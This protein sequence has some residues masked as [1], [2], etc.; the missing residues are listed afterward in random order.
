MQQPRF[1]FVDLVDIEPLTIVDIGASALE[2]AAAYHV[3]AE[4]TASRII[5]FEPDPKACAALNAA[6]RLR[7]SYFPFAIGAGGPATL[8]ETA[9]PPSSSLYK[10][11][12]ELL[13]HFTNFDKLFAVTRTHK[14]ET[15]RLDDVISADEIDF[16]KI[17]VQGA[18][19]DVLRGAEKLL[20]TTLVV[21]T[22]VEFLPMYENQPLFGDIDAH[23]RAAGFQL[24]TFFDPR[25]PFYTPLADPQGGLGD[26][27]QVMWTDAI[28]VPDVRRLHL[29][30][31]ERLFKLVT[32]L[33]E[34]YGSVDL[35]AHILKHMR[36]RGIETPFNEYMKRCI[37]LSRA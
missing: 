27:S 18:E 22:E 20:P 35:C 12:A 21:Q 6:G 15:H 36:K 26:F 5:G 9:F 29:Y 14:V 37:A 34:M 13:S 32:L 3:L 4:R 16:L 28:Y 2:G 7:H 19:L 17:D 24:H 25:R 8:Y 11:D 33:H 30:S 23:L 31:Q 10:P 1:S